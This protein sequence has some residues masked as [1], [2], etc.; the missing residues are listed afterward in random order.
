MNTKTLILR[1]R[2]GSWPQK[3][4]RSSPPTVRGAAVL[5]EL[6]FVFALFVFTKH[7]LCVPMTQERRCDLTLIAVCRFLQ[8]VASAERMRS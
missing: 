2:I 4:A 3:S 8:L 6:L 7:W 5:F 1:Q